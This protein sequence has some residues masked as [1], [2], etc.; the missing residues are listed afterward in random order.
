MLKLTQLVE[1]L[2]T[3]SLELFCVP[4]VLRRARI[5]VRLLS[6]SPSIFTV[7]ALFGSAFN[8]EKKDAS[9]QCLEGIECNTSMSYA[10]RDSSIKRFGTCQTTLSSDLSA[11]LSQQPTDLRPGPRPE[12]KSE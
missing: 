10:I 9:L 11:D 8:Y 3:E 5:R 6:F 4:S 12:F 2:K 1:R 7:L